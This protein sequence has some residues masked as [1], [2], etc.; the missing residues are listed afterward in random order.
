M[1]ILNIQV[2]QNEYY[3]GKTNM[4]SLLRL[5]TTNIRKTTEMIPNYIKTDE[6]YVKVRINCIKTNATH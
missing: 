2:K 4:Q 1:C 3:Y 6:N 5:I